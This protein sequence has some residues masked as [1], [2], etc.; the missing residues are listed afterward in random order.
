MEGGGVGVLWGKSRVETE[1]RKMK[2]EYLAF[3]VLG[4]Q[5]RKERKKNPHALVQI[6]SSLYFLPIWKER[7]ML[8][9]WRTLH[10]PFPRS[11]SLQTI[12]GFFFSFL[13]LSSHAFLPA[14]LQPN[15]YILIIFLPIVFINHCIEYG[16]GQELAKPSFF[17][18]FFL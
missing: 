12:K 13:S 4:L 14:S 8:A 2:W 16:V 5:G 15:I 10:F 1:R 18:F 3:K 17:F 11:I 6:L 7:K 9:L